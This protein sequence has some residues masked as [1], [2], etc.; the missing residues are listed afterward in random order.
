MLPPQSSALFFSPPGRSSQVKDGAGHRGDRAGGD[1]LVRHRGE[2]DGE[3]DDDD[4]EEEEEEEEKD[5]DGDFVF[6]NG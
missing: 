4:D 1:Q 2:A 5:D 3:D 6:V